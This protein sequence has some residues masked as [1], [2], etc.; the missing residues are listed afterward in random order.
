MPLERGRPHDPVEFHDLRIGQARIGLG[1][2]HQP[3]VVP[4][5]EGV[6]AVEA[7]AATVSRLRVEQHGIDLERLDLPLPPVT[8]DA[9]HAVGT[10]SP[11]EHESFH[12]PITRR[13]PRGGERLPRFT[14]DAWRVEES[15]GQGG[16]VLRDGGRSRHGRGRPDAG[17]AGEGHERLEPSASF[18][19][20]QAA[21]VD[22]VEFE[23]VV[24]DEHAGNLVEQFPGHTPP[25]APLRDRSEAEE[26]LPPHR[27]QFAVEHGAG[28]KC[29]G[30]RH[31][32][33][34]GLVDELLATAPE[35]G[36][37]AAP[38]DLRP[39][40]VPLPFRDPVG[41]G[42]QV[43]RLALDRRR[44]QEG[45][46]PPGVGRGRLTRHETSVG[47]GIG[48]AGP[49]Q[50]VGHHRRI[51]AGHLRQRPGHERP[52]HAHAA[53]AGEQFVPDDSLPRGE[54]LPDMLHCRPLL[55]VVG[56]PQFQNRGPHAL[57]QSHADALRDRLG[58]LMRQDQRQ[59]FGQIADVGITLLH[60][61]EWNARGLR[62]PRA[63]QGG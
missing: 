18:R 43:A 10:R 17:G 11:L 7:G 50:P 14:D 34:K 31:D 15:R 21:H 4:D 12:T 2:R 40:P 32:L 16:G 28:W 33:R 22:A 47:I 61:P 42:A 44:Q 63:E 41:D 19:Q 13:A 53:P 23:Q 9:A 58:T 55:L 45:I 46:G 1:H 3:A 25:A 24:G 56:V 59:G 54:P 51:D 26:R 20:R 62:S 27:Q 38:H 5:A 29:G 48:D 52:R 6:V 37:V 36:V 60:Q 8:A 39:H 30:R 35:R 49:H 57:G